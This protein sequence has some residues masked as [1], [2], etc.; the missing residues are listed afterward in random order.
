MSYF[1]ATLFL[2]I[3]SSSAFAMDKNQK[4]AKSYHMSGQVSRADCKCDNEKTTSVFN[5]PDNSK[6]TYYH[7][8]DSPKNNKK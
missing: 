7:Y 4:E 1:Y 6:S 5:Y 8:K 3:L 2:I